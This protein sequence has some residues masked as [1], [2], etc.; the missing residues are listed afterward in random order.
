[1]AAPRGPQRAWFGEGGPARVWGWRSIVFAFGGHSVG[2]AG[3]YRRV[4]NVGALCCN[5]LRYVVQVFA[6][7]DACGIMQRQLK[8]KG[9]STAMQYNANRHKRD[10]CQTG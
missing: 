5:T 3:A 9:H 2:P 4:C 7:E 6:I 8:K 1:M 10:R